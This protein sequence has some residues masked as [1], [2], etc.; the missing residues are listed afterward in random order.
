[1]RDTEC[2]M[3]LASRASMQFMPET[4]LPTLDCHSADLLVKSR[5]Y[6]RQP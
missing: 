5:Q 3:Q 4:C 6:A 1:M 2:S